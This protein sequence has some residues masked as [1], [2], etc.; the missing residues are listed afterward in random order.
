MFVNNGTKIHNLFHSGKVW[1]HRRAFF[2]K[3]RIFFRKKFVFIYSLHI[4][5]TKEI[6]YSQVNTIRK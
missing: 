6:D 3:K 1:R 5:A 2:Q 4:F